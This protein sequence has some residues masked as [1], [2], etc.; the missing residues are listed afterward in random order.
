M[1]DMSASAWMEVIKGLI[2]RI[3]KSL[4][5]HLNLNV[6]ARSNPMHPVKQQR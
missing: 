3:M 1:T 4:S 2:M 6:H 5:H